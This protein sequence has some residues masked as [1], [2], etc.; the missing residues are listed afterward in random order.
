MAIFCVISGY[1]KSDPAI[2]FDYSVS[3]KL[4]DITIVPEAYAEREEV[5]EKHLTKLF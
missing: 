4:F 1:A 2:E 3:V 5:R